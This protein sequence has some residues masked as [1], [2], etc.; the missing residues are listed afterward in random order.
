[1]GAVVERTV[2]FFSFFGS[3]SGFGNAKVTFGQ[4]QEREYVHNSV[5][6]AFLMRSFQN[7]RMRNNSRKRK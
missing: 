6:F 5:E 3:G 2:A 4:C 1:M 7:E